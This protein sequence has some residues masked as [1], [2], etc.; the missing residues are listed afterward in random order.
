MTRARA[1]SVRTCVGC[2][3][4]NHPDDLLR[5]VVED[6]IAIPDPT[7]SRGGRGAWLH[8]DCLEMAVRRRAF[9]RALRMT[10]APDLSV[11]T[12]YVA[13]NSAKAASPSAP[14]A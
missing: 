3:E 10:S 9:G 8:H 14:E 4:R 12:A 7:A 2:R 13:S 1:S 5:V 11:L 6:G